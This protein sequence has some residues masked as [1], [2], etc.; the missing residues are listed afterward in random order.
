MAFFINKAGVVQHV[1]ADA[2]GP[3]VYA[4]AHAANLSVPQYVNRTFA[5]D[6]DLSK[7][8]PFQQMCASEGLVSQRNNP[9]GLRSL[10]LADVLSGQGFEL[11]TG[12]GNVNTQQRG[13]PFGGQSRVLFPAAIIQMIE[14]V[15]DKDRV[16]DGAAFNDLVALDISISDE[17]FIQPVISYS[18]TGG[19]QE[20][21]AQRIAQ[22]AL[23]PKLVSFTTS[24]RNR[25]VP[26]W[27]IGAEFSD[28][29]LR[30]STLDI[31]AL[32]MSRFMEVERDAHNYEYLSGI[33]T[34]DDANSGAV[35]SVSASA[36]DSAATG[37]SI[38]HKLWVKFLARNRRY[39]KVSHV[40]G[41]IDSYLKFE[42]RAGRPGSNSYDP[43]LTRIDPQGTMMNNTFGGDVKWFL[44]DLATEGG[45]V[46]ANTVWALDKRFGIVRVRNV[47]ADYKAAEAFVMS[48]KTELRID[49]AEMCYR[50]FG[51]SELKAFD[52]LT[53]TT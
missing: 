33:F 7:G 20:T 15:M 23:P 4:Q 18:G 31:V 29:A 53:L 42:Q 44:V 38:T 17:N 9:F 16:T 52:S 3:Y 51:D 8:T 34:G 22:L 36:I 39:R 40:V 43:T 2:V 21:R 30:A 5:K 41:D 37:F 24:D 6:C 48:R 35:S 50:M 46:A 45:P 10:S 19:P 28:Q 12:G 26:T 1:S 13:D 49:W 47:K 25:S 11:A 27:S 14:D 32:T